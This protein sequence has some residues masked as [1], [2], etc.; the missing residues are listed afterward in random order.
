[1][2][3]REKV[4]YFVWKYIRKKITTLKYKL[5][6]IYLGEYNVVCLRVWAIYSGEY[7]VVC[8][9][10]FCSEFFKIYIQQCLAQS[11]KLKN[12]MVKTILN[13]GN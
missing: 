6:D 9:E 8:L 2:L 5:W 4:C 3:K 13:Y 7:T 10:D 1:M 12:L 11:L